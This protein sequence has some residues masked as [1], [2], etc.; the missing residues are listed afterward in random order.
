MCLDAYSI[1]GLHF[2]KRYA[3]KL[4]IPENMDSRIIELI[5]AQNF[6]QI[7]EVGTVEPKFGLSGHKTETMEMVVDVEDDGMAD[8]AAAL[9]VRRRIVVVGTSRAPD[10]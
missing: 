9:L 3:F 6:E 1:K 2:A 7:M 5:M 4:C 10:S 8:E